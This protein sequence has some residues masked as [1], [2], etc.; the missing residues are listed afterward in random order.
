MTL[1]KLMGL[2]IQFIAKEYLHKT[3]STI[4]NQHYKKKNVANFEKLF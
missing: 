1:S 3:H 2:M 4:F